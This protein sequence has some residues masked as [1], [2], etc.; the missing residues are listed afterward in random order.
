MSSPIDPT[1]WNPLKIPFPTVQGNYCDS[2]ISQCTGFANCSALEYATELR[3]TTPRELTDEEI[4]QLEWEGMWFN[5]ISNPVYIALMSVFSF[6]ILVLVI[7]GI[8]YMKRR[9]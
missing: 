1:T 9:K 3:P 4:A 6:F 5:Q 7:L 2:N 8:M